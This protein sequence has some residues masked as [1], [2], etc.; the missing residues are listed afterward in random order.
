MKLA[1][2][3]DQRRPA[4]VTIATSRTTSGSSTGRSASPGCETE[5]SGMKHTPIPA[6]TM[7]WIQ[8]SRSLR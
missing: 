4:T 6:A 5:Y 8:S 1:T 2:G 7:V 3:G